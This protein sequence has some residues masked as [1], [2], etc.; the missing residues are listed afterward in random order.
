MP[1]QTWI[2]VQL[3]LLLFKNYA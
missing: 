1:Q 2:I 3:V